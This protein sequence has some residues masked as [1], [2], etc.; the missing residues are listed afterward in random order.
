MK[1]PMFAR[2]T[3][4]NDTPLYVNP[5]HVVSFRDIECGA[6]VITSE[7]APD[8]EWKVKETAEAVLA[9]LQQIT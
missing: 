4:L 5:L 2:L 9:K 7:M 3:L 1:F 8:E 6:S